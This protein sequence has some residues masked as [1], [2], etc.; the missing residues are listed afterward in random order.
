MFQKELE[1]AMNLISLNTQKIWI[2]KIL[3]QN[4][5]LG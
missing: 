3:I 4:G 5:L 1:K 2:L